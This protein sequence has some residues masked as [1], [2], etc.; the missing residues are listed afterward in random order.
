MAFGRRQQDR[1]KEAAHIIPLQTGMTTWWKASSVSVNN[2]FYVH[3]YNNHA[4]W[5]IRCQW[6]GKDQSHIFW[7]AVLSDSLGIKI[8]KSSIGAKKWWLNESHDK[9]KRAHGCNQCGATNIP[10]SCSFWIGFIDVKMSCAAITDSTPMEVFRTKKNSSDHVGRCHM[11]CK[12]Q[13]CWLGLN[14]ACRRTM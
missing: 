8:E 5:R 2:I 4:Y 1:L 14:T 3:M 6:N 9:V 7:E 10:E 12:L 11:A 13:S